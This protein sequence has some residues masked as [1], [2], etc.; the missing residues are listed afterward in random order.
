MLH[1]IVDLITS[2]KLT[3]VC[4]AAGMALIFAGTIAQVHLGIHEAQERYFQSFF[5]WWPPDSATWK[6]PVFPGGHLIGAI[7]L[8]NLIAAHAARFRWAWRKFGIHLPHAGL[9]IMLAG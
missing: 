8:I 7:L 5:V 6:I 3:I 9:I 4:L 2:L 1:K